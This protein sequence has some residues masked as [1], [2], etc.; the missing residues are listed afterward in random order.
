[1]RSGVACRAQRDQVVLRVGSQM[2]GELPV[3]DLKTR[4]R[5]TGLTPLAVAT[6][7]LL[8]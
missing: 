3:V 5:A 2:A 1:M 4:H 7:D 6:Q 8:A